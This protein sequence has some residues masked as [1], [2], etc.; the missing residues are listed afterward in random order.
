MDIGSLVHIVVYCIV[1]GC[2]L[3]L[4]LYLVNISPVPDPYKGWLRFLVL[5]AT[6]LIIIYILLGFISGG[7]MPKIRMGF[8]PSLTPWSI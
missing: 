8:L 6:I 3:G 1:V 4:L 5:A 2:I 7:S